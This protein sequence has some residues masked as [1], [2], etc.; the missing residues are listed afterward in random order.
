MMAGRLMGGS[1]RDIFTAVEAS[2]R[3]LKTEWDEYNLLARDADVGA[4]LRALA[5]PRA[6]SRQ[7][8]RAA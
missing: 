5:H 6:A 3:R 2:L 1:L 7:H 8:R 4:A